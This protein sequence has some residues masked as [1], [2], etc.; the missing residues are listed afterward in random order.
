[1]NKIS[2]FPPQKSGKSRWSPSAVNAGASHT[3]AALRAS[4]SVQRAD[5]ALRTSE[6]RFRAVVDAAFDAIIIISPGGEIVSFNRGAEHMFGY[7]ALEVIGEPIAMLMPRSFPQAMGD[8]WYERR[9]TGQAIEL[10]GVHLNATTFPLEAVVTDVWDD[11]G[12]VSIVI[13]RDT[14]ER[15]RAEAQ[16]RHAAL[17]DP[18]TDLP[19][20]E[21][22][23]DRLGQAFGRVQRRQ[24]RN[25]A[26]VFVEL[27][28]FKSI[29]ELL[30]HDWGDY[31]LVNVGR[32]LGQCVR[33]TDT[34]A[35]LNG[36]EFA[37]LLEDPA[38][39]DDIFRIVQRIE[40][41]LMVPL[42]RENQQIQ[43]TASIG[44][45]PGALRHTRTEE[46]LREADLALHRAKANGRACHVMYDAELHAHTV[47]RLHLESDLNTALEREEFCLV[48]QPII[49]LQT[50]ALTAFEALVRWQHPVRGLISPGEFIPI[51]EETGMILTLDN[52]VLHKACR[53]LALWRERIPEAA[54]VALN[55]NLS[56]KNI[57]PPGLVEKIRAVVE[58]THLPASQLHLE[59][60]ESAL[61][62]DTA[63]ATVTLE[64]LQA[65]GV[66]V[67]I[68]D[69]GTGY[70]SLVYMHQF[71]FNG[72]KLDRAFLTGTNAA[73]V[74]IIRAGVLLAHS[75]GLE[76]VAEGIETAEQALAL[77]ALGCDFGQGYY[78]AR[79]VDATKAEAIMHGHGWG[80]CAS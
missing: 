7:H 68:D 37:V 72:L 44:I 40:R 16:L 20:R 74:E 2:A 12:M 70:S 10:V 14:T 23:L 33:A 45:A 58:E 55:I 59:I 6:A 22:F 77:T 48:Y 47:A 30:G 69:F 15:K 46:V 34:V 80:L 66:S 52:W 38:D 21:L 35:R 73:R 49:S 51:M 13:L 75:I 32:R 5:A 27:D 56:T 67:Y 57:G 36:D 76:V 71:V 43:I 1:M 39:T 4:E 42:E 24:N 8:T 11:S 78:C 63:L 62:E 9:L 28:R 41:A 64:E 60:T 3:D 18:L 25:F 31:V 19:N 50:G 29:N 26:M 61:L 53:Q 79:P 17:H 54:S 65:L